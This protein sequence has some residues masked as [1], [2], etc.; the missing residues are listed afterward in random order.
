MERKV[1]RWK[2]YLKALP[3]IATNHSFHVDLSNDPWTSEH[4]NP[5][6]LTWNLK[7][8]PQKLTW[9]PKSSLPPENLTLDTQNSHIW[10]ELL[11]SKPFIFGIHVE[12]SGVRYS[13]SCS[14]YLQAT[15]KR[16]HLGCWTSITWSAPAKGTSDHPSQHPTARKLVC[17]KWDVIILKFNP[18]KICRS[19][20][21]TRHHLQQCST[22][23]CYMMITL[24]NFTSKIYLHKTSSDQNIQIRPCN[25]S[26]PSLALKGAPVQNRGERQKQLP[27]KSIAS[28]GASK[29]Q[30]NYE[31]SWFYGMVDVL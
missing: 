4:Y 5:Q 6:K 2:L 31:S 27:K 23:W 16:L 18:T 22:D 28:H 21:L 13:C 1:Q 19:T 3:K 24:G 12:S 7:M 25:H 8:N 29:H 15:G 20:P 11:F 9:N 14:W 10:K 30:L 26:A 17:L